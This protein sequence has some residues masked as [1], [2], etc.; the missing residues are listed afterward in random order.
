MGS[1]AL[2]YSFIRQPCVGSQ[3]PPEAGCIG[4]CAASGSKSGSKIGQP[5]HGAG[6]LTQ[7]EA[8]R[9]TYVQGVCGVVGRVAASGR[10]AR[11]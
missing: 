3:G 6:G 8:V 11:L 10:S 7:L 1:E 2:Y 4:L 9:S 5:G